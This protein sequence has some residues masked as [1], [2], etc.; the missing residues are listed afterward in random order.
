MPH[1]GPVYTE[2]GDPG[3]ITP[4]GGV[5]KITRVYAFNLTAPSSHCVLSQS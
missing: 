5:K 4:S 2:M 3:N 1:L